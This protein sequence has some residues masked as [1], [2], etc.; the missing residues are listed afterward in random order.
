MKKKVTIFLSVVL[1]A[2]LIVMA[3]ILMPNNRVSEIFKKKIVVGIADNMPFSQPENGDAPQGLSADLAKLIFEKLGY[4][5]EFRTVTSTVR[6]EMLQ[7]GE[8]DCYVDALSK[9]RE[10]TL[11]STVYFSCLQGS[12][13]KNKDLRLGEIGDLKNFRVAY[14]TDGGAADIIKKYSATGVAKANAAE[15][16][17]AIKSDEADL[18][19]LDADT[20]HGLKNGEGEFAAYTAGIY[21]FSEEH[22][23]AFKNSNKELA[24]NVNKTLT[25]F[26]RNGKIKEL[27]TKYGLA[28]SVA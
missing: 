5:V 25:E 24:A 19:I 12:F 9:N 27:I 7:S 17:E 10:N 6:D 1:A 8:I 18:C 13:Y 28:D 16:L 21:L 2:L 26:T 23:F 3:L 11:Y 14:I 4:Q 15:V 20:I 22:C